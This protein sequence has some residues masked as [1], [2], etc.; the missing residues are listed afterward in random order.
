M[1]PN[2]KPRGIGLFLLLFLGLFIAWASLFEIDETV[3]AQGLV[4]AQARNQV[5]QAADGGV[6]SALYVREGDRVT[7]GQV[8]AQLET[9]RARAGVEEVR[10]NLIS[11]EVAKTRALAEANGTEPNF[12]AYAEEFADA[13]AAQM[14]LYLENRRALEQERSSILASLEIAHAELAAFEDLAETGDAS[15]LEVMQKRRSVIELEGDLARAVSDYTIEARR[16]IAKIEQDSASLRFQLQERQTALEHTRIESPVEGYVTSLEL[17]TL[18]GVLRGGDQLMHITPANDPM[19]V[20]IKISPVDIGH[21][22]LGLPVS[23][24]F[25]AFESTIYGSL[26]GRLEYISPDTL[27]EQGPDGRTQTFYRGHVMLRED[28]QNTRLSISEVL[29][30]GSSASV[31]IQTGSRS[32][33]VFLAKPVLRAFSGALTQR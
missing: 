6:L 22:S 11:L 16:E 7:Q 15:R 21:L 12:D 1:K 17:N 31:D 13:A 25:D 30:P 14:A 24:K 32:I 29:R 8:V 19:L 20:E 3:R 28:Q 26:D 2:R 9:G 10:A 4:I 27:S 33:L 18:G 5:I 23:V